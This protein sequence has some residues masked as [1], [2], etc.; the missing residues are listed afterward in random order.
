M[1]GLAV[2]EQKKVVIVKCQNGYVAD[3]NP[4]NIGLDKLYVFSTFADLTDWLFE[5][6]E[7]PKA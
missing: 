4:N 7:R 2:S 6:M 1:G 5:Y 3:T